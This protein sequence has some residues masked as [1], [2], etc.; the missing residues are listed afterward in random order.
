MRLSRHR[1]LADREFEFA[2]HQGKNPL[3]QTAAST[4]AESRIE[5]IPVLRDEALE[6]DIPGW[7]MTTLELEPGRTMHGV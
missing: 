3:W 1:H 2:T 5:E 4:L 7:R 6:V